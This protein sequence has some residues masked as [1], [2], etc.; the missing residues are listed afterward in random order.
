M[1]SLVWKLAAAALINGALVTAA[2]AAAC[3]SGT[4][5]DFTYRST[6]ASQ[7]EAS[8]GNDGDPLT[9]F[10]Q[11]WAQLVKFDGDQNTA[12]NTVFPGSALPFGT[13]PNAGTIKFS[14]KFL[15]LLSDGY[16][17]FDLLVDDTPESMVPALLDLVG[18][19]K[20]ANGYQAYLFENAYVGDSGN[21]G[22]FKVLWDKKETND[23]SHFSIY[24]RDYQQCTDT[25]PGCGGGGANGN[26]VPE[27]A[28]LA[29]VGLALVGVAAARRRQRA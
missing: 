16:Y 6:S 13:A 9:A 25:T 12:V 4:E 29:L 8:A 21:L 1:N 17:G 2:S 22:T 26:G 7:C 23:F 19:T 11:E 10:G 24:G 15:G 18:V 14:L 28:T 5:D 27:P 3:V 20:Q